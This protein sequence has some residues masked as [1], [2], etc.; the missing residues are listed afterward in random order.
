[1]DEQRTQ[2]SNGNTL[3]LPLALRIEAHVTPHDYFLLE[4]GN[5]IQYVDENMY[6]QP[7][8]SIPKN[9]NWV[10]TYPGTE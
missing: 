7:Y 1:M 8:D 10:H 9:Q 6:S 2:V 4:I 5:K 3:M